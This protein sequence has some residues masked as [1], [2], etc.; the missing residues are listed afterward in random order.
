LLEHPELILEVLTLTGGACGEALRLVRH[1]CV[2]GF[3]LHDRQQGTLG[4][5]QRVW[6][7]V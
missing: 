4:A 1:H 7:K 6:R 5:E 2:A 3:V